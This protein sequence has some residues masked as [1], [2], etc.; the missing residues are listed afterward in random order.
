MASRSLPTLNLVR[1]TPP[2]EYPGT[3]CRPYPSW[4]LPGWNRLSAGLHLDDFRKFFE[5]P[6]GG[7]DYLDH[8]PPIITPGD[9]IGCGYTF[10]SGTLFFTYNGQRLPPA[11]TG[12]YLPRKNHDVFAVVGVEGE[13][14]FEVNFGGDGF[15]WLEGNEWPWRVE[16]H[17]GV[18]DGDGDEFPG[19]ELPTYRQVRFGG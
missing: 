19:D 16:G 2:F 10:S 18:L 15:R 1:L 11:F 5:D 6:D 7:R 4:R 13:C 3:S 9:T 17:V 8:P 12:I 14:E